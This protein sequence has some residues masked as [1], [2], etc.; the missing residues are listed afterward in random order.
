M[1]G[2]ARQE[3]YFGKQL[4]LDEIIA[5]I[6]KVSL[7]DIANVANTI[8]DPDSI[9]LTLIGNMKSPGVTTDMLRSALG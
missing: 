5:S 2:L 4:S 1:S 3:Y 7:D 6:D 8:V 9:S